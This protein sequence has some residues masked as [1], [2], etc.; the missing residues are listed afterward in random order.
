MSQGIGMMLGRLLLQVLFT[1]KEVA[2]R[3]RMISLLSLCYLLW[4]MT[5]ICNISWRSQNG[6]NRKVFLWD[7]DLLKSCACT[8]AQRKVQSKKWRPQIRRLS[9][10]AVAALKP[11]PGFAAKGWTPSL[12]T[13]CGIGQLRWGEI[14]YDLKWLEPGNQA[15]LKWQKRHRR[16]SIKSWKGLYLI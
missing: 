15:A 6:R 12:F 2:F 14:N 10:A 3:W 4:K 16:F 7:F 13:L 8:S 1:M 5:S 11:P 9:T